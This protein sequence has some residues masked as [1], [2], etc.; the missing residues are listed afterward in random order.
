MSSLA[1]T[2]RLVRF[3]VRRDRVRLLVWVLG[4]GLTVLVS[5]ASLERT[6]PTQADR[7]ARAQVFESGAAKLLVGP[8][9]GTDDYT[10]GAMTANELLPVTAVAIALM[11][12]FMVVRNT[13]GEEERGRSELVRASAVGRHAT[14]ASA[15]VVVVGANVFLFAI[16]ATGLP[17]SLGELSGRGSVAFAASLL[18]VGLVFASVALLVA[19]MTVSARSALGISAVVIGVTYLVR[20]VGDM[21]DTLAPWFSPFGWGTEI[22]AYVDARWWP[23]ALSAG[24]T[25]ILIAGAVWINGRRD[26]GGGIIGDRPGAVAAG[27]WLT[28]P[29]GLAFRLERASLIAWSV[30][31]FLVGLLYGAVAEGAG[32]L[33]EDVDVLHNY[34][35]RI[36]RADPVDQFLALSVFI[37]ALIAGGFAIQSALRLRDEESAQRAEPVLASQVSRGRWVWSHLAISL[38]GSVVLLLVIGLGVG[39]TGSI[40]GDDLG[41][42]PRL[43]GSSLAYAPALWVLVGLTGA[44]FGAA[45]RLVSVM[46]VLLG[47][48]T[49]IGFLGPPLQL[50]DW[51]FDL[52]PLEHVSRLPVGAFSV[53]PEL[54]LT[55]IAGALLTVSV[56]AFRRRDLTSP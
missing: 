19:Q 51:V 26:L 30:S 35:S 27:R 34:L 2:L 33:Y 32:T 1:G 24:T 37:S 7:R 43:M 38:G 41:E 25:A 52:S 4:I 40:G 54:I 9:Y 56:L 3:T 28:R 48:L 18:G 23:L 17:V 29:F 39:I 14:A 16:L 6:Y 53:V 31:L 20:A 5:V 47:S 21:G 55:G 22:R 11:G 10:F 36:V 44:L 50:P 13:R 45:P 15:L 42:L 46:W 8:G 12:T 49:F